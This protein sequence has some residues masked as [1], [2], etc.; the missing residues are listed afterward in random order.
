VRPKTIRDAEGNV[1]Y[2]QTTQDGRVAMNT[3]GSPVRVA[4]EDIEQI[5]QWLADARAELL[6]GERW[7]P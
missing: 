6:Q 2:L 3:P 1:M 5:R 7:T 4:P